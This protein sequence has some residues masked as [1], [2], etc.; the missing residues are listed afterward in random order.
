MG[1][2]VF[3]TGVADKVDYIARLVR[4]GSRQGARM[5]VVCED[6]AAVSTALWGGAPVDFVVHATAHSDAATWLA[7]SVV[8]MTSPSVPG[9]DLSRDVLVNACEAW[10]E[11][12][13]QYLR[14]IELV[15]QAPGDVAAGR[16]RWKKY[17]SAGVQPDKLG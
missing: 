6:P 15:G 14:V 3:H 12:H 7:S 1:Q 13:A 10:P 2:V 11:T 8:L 16:E 17:M 5:V 4:K 9:R